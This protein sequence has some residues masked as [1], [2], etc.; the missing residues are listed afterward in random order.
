MNRN[1]ARELAA[2]R[3]G[4]VHGDAQQRV[5][6]AEE[7]YRPQFRAYGRAELAFLRGELTRG[8]LDPE[9][10]SPWWRAVNDRLLHDKL[11]AALLH[12]AGSTD[13][14]RAPVGRIPHRAFPFGLVPGA[15]SQCRVRLYG[16][17]GAGGGRT[18]QLD[19]PAITGLVD[20]GSPCYPGVCI[21]PWQL[22]TN[23]MIRLITRATRA[24]TT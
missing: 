13:D 2:R 19:E 12:R 3:V 23:S 8:M 18:R 24:R 20:N 14:R 22:A 16:A 10:G 6:L 15:Q 21:D 4:A 17:L 5:A 7:S 11:E 1:E 9:T